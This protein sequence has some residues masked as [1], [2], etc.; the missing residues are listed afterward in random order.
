VTDTG[1]GIPADRLSRIYLEFIGAG[2]PDD[3]AGLGLS[4]TRQLVVLMGGRVTV[5]SRLGEGTTFSLRLP[6]I[7]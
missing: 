4:L 1:P 2:S 6:A 5:R 3:G 7:G